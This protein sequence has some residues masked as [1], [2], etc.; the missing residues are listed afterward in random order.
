MFGAQGFKPCHGLSCSNQSLQP[1]E[2]WGCSDTEVLIFFFQPI[3]KCRVL[4]IILGVLGMVTA[5]QALILVS[6]PC[7]HHIMASVI[8][9]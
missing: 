3:L 9:L 4:F 8:S 6:A 1:R 7:S 2:G 5:Y